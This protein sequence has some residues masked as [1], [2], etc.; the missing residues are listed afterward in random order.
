MKT[1]CVGINLIMK[2]EGCRLT[3]YKCPSG[4][5]TIGYG[6]TKGVKKGMKI[7]KSKAVSYLKQD[8]LVYENAVNKY[9]KV[10]LKQNQFDALVSFTFNCGVGALR[11]STLLKKLNKKDYVGASNEFLR[12]NKSNGKVLNGLTRRRKEEKKLFLG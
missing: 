10:P 1:S 8:L 3:A 5:W 9:V 6:H 2:F 4:V 12:W 11:T 7:T